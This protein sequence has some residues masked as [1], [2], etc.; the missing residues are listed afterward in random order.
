MTEKVLWYMSNC[1]LGIAFDLYKLNHL[2]KVAVPLIHYCSGVST[3][4][5]RQP[6]RSIL[7]KLS[8]SKK[9][10]E[11]HNKTRER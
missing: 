9:L 2:S 7:V 11:I 8:T 1:L 10:V 6:F 3:A 5:R 4:K